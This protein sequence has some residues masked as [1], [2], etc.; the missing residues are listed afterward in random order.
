MHTS[1]LY[2][3]KHTHTHTYGIRYIVFIDILTHKIYIFFLG[4]NIH[5][6]SETFTYT[7]I[8]TPTIRYTK[9]VDITTHK[10]QNIHK[11]YTLITRVYQYRNTKHI[12]SELKKK[13]FTSCVDQS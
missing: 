11:H 5:K 12:N 9:F 6:H 13:T 1:N 3:H 4:D 7:D 8:L 10:I 2:T